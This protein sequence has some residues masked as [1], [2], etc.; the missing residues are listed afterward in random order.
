M[1]L[2]FLCLCR[3]NYDI[4]ND[5]PL[6]GRYEW[7]RVD[8]QEGDSAEANAQFLQETMEKKKKQKR[9]CVTCDL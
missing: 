3:Y 8:N 6:P 9:I 2:I 7:V 5:M 1:W 4:M